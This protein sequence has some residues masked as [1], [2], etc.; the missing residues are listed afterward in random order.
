VSLIFSKGA[1]TRIR[2]RPRREAAGVARQSQPEGSQ[3]H[4]GAIKPVGAWASRDI[5]GGTMRTSAAVAAIG[6]ILVAGTVFG[7]TSAGGS[8]TATTI[9]LYEHD[10]S[11]ANID[12]GAPG[13]SA[14]DQF[15]F[16]GDAFKRKGGTQVGR[17]AGTCTTM[18][19][20][21]AGEVLCVVN[22]SLRNGHIAAQGLFVTADLF[23][24]KTGT[25]PI[26]GGTGRYR[27]ARGEG[28]IQIPPDV[29][30]LTDAN[31]TLRLR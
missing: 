27:R 24:G 21:A 22:F 8:S 16:A 18:S 5:N 28:T 17:V 26:T 6:A 23:G 13:E 7:T 10:T 19:T 20:G 2:S 3:K 1:P 31:F 12:L 25:F 14:G 15:L 9:R 29:P 11:Q 4:D 30:D